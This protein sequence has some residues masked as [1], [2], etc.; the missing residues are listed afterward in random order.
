M[1]FNLFLEKVKLYKKQ[2]LSFFI[3]FFIAIIWVFGYNY[4]FNSTFKVLAWNFDFS[5]RK[6]PF[7]VWFIDFTLSKDLDKSTVIKD[8]FIISPKIDWE[9]SLVWTNIIRYKFLQK[10]TIWDDI[11]VTL[12]QSIKSIKWENLDQEYNYIISVIESPKVLKISP[13]WELDNLAQNIAVFFNIPMIPLT[14]LDEKDKLPC[15]IEIEPKLDWVCKWTT[16]SVMEF[17]PKDWFLWATKYKVTVSNKEWLLY[18]MWTWST[19]EISTPK[20]QYFVDERFSANDNIKIRFN[21]APDLVSLQSKLSLLE[22]NLKKDIYLSYD[23]TNESSVIVNIKWGRYKFDKSYVLKFDKWIMPKYGNEATKTEE[24]KTTFSYPF[25]N[26]V[27]V[28]QNIFSWSKLIDTMDFQNKAFIPSKNM[29]LKMFFEDRI[30]SLDTNLFS[31]EDDKWNKV[32][33]T[34]TYVREENIETKAISENKEAITLNL[35]Q[36]LKSNTKYK[37]IIKKS[38]NLNLENDIEREFQTSPDFLVT[39]Y[40]FLSYSKSCLYLN[41]RVWWDIWTRANDFLDS[42]PESKVTTVSEWEYIEYKDQIALWLA[43]ASNTYSPEVKIVTKNITDINYIEKWYCPPAKNWDNLY[44]IN[45]RLNPNSTYKINVKNTLDDE[46]WNLLFKPF[47]SEVKT[48]DIQEQDKYLYISLNKEI[49]LIPT[50]LPIVVNLQ[51]INLDNIDVEICELDKYNYIQYVNNRWEQWFVPKCANTYT[52]NLKVKNNHW[53]L[54]N[55]KFDVEKDIIGAISKANYILVKWN[56]GWRNQF[57]NVFIRS[58]LNV[59]FESAKNKNLLFVTDFEWNKIPNL[60]IEFINYNYQNKSISN[61]TPKYTLNKDT[62]VY[63]IEWGLWYNYIIVSNDKYTWIVDLNNNMFQDYDFK[64]VGWTA[65]SDMNY[66]YLYTERPIYKPGDTVFIKWLLRKFEYN[67]Y[68]KSGIKAGKLEILDQNYN[69]ISTLDIKLDSN[70]NFNSSFIIPKE[71]PLWE[72]SFRFKVWNVWMEEYYK[73]DAHFYIEEYKK[74]DFKIE[75]SWIKKDYSMWEKS[76]FEVMPKYYFGWNMVSTKWQYSVLTQNYFFDAKDYSNYQFGQGYEYFDCVYWGYCS[77]EDNLSDV[78][79]F[80]VNE[81]WKAIINYTFNSTEEKEKIYNFNVEVE[82]KDTKKTVNK[83]VSAIVHNTD[84]YVWILLPYY[85]EKKTWIKGE[86]ITLDYDANPVSWKDVKVEVIKR[87][88]KMVKKEWVDWVFYS[89]YAIEET[90]ESEFN[91]QTNKLGSASQVI[92]TKDSWEYMIKASY[93]W[94]NGKSFVSSSIVYV[95]WDDYVSWYSPNNDTTELVSEKVQVLSWDTAYYTLKTPINTWKALIII[96]KDDGILDYFVHDIKSYWD[97]IAI[98]VKSTYYPNYYLR[99]FVIWSEKWNDLP[100]YKRALTSTKVSTEYKKLNISLIKDKESYKPGD[101]VWIWVVVLDS[102]WNPIGWANGSIS[103]VDE[104]LLAL[105]WNPKKNPYAF[106]YDMKRYLWTLMYSSMINLI[107][108]LEVKDIT[109]WEKW[110]AWEQI[111]WWDSKKKRW[112]FKD[113]AFWQ[114][115][116]TTWKNW[117]VYIQ[118]EALPDNLTTWV[119]EVLVNT[120][121]DNKIWVAYETLTTTKKVIISDNLP[122]FFWVGDKITLSPVVFNKT[123]KDADFELSLD[124]TNVV[125]KWWNTRKLFIKSWE[126]KSINFNIEVNK[127][128]KFRFINV[129]SSKLDFKVKEICKKNCSLDNEDEIEKTVQIKDSTTRESVSTVWSTKDASFDEIIDI[130]HIKN[131]MGQVK[132]NYGATLF[133]NLVDSIDYLNNYPYGCAEQKTSSITPNIYIKKLYDSVWMSFDLK[134]KMIDYYD[135]EER[136]YKKKSLDQVIKE[137]IVDIRKF[138]KID[139]WFVY[140]YDVDSRYPN[141]SDYHL[142][143]YIL[144]SLSQLW[145]LGYKQEEKIMLDTVAY[146]KARFYKNQIEWCV[147]TSLNDCKYNELDRLSAIEAIQNYKTDDYETYKMYKLITLKSDDTTSILKKSIVVANLLKIKSL[148]EDEKTSLKAEVKKD[149]TKVINNELVYNPR[150]AYIGKSSEFTRVENTSLLLKA[151]SMLWVKEIDNSA[152]IIDNLNRWIIG[153][154]KNWTFWSTQDNISVIDAISNYMLSS[155]E[156]KDIN[157]ETKIKLNWNNVDEKVF[158]DKNKLEIVSKY[159]DIGSLKDKNTLNISKTWNWKV[160][161]DLSMDYYLPSK[162]VESRDEWFAVIKEYYDYNQYKKIDSLKKEEW[163]LY[164]KWKK[165]YDDLKYK[166]E[167]YEYLTKLTSFT[168]WQLVV[169]RNRVI[170]SETRDKVAFEWFIPAWAE[171]VNPNL[172][173]ST[174]AA[175]SFWNDIFERKEYRLDRFFGYTTTLQSWIYDV[176]YLVRFTHTGEYYV[177]PSY[178]NEFYNTEVFGRSSGEMIMVK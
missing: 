45:T 164:T 20:L 78:K 37:L 147:V 173:T 3:A 128:E 19:V 137:Y 146:L 155:E 49:N 9:V 135:S 103:I 145:G 178:I 80:R 163:L 170:T 66:L 154:K 72:F 156:L 47:G 123:W 142:T 158:N 67:W 162:N 136:A 97:R 122:S 165:S 168:V 12:K 15:P 143:S 40:K 41:N 119:V 131:D 30:G 4:Y 62:W 17:I 117:K 126:S 85:N 138:Q 151:I 27:L 90:K 130:S 43:T 53:N 11:S 157:F 115:D 84:S 92:K 58:D 73:N 38:I 35:K 34:L 89:D 65:T 175:F 148:S 51:T 94:K 116:F 21:F 91:L 167:T 86:F 172:A 98:K 161:Y 87:E 70:S 171:L 105:V 102:K 114:A 46:Y 18:K 52:K 56:A 31:F 24:S 132:V 141:Y 159:L 93:T 2:I 152:Y 108:K 79:E 44:V 25:L 110:W 133:N 118:S 140:W 1:Q 75:V 5:Y 28:Y 127:R 39:D 71:S 106:F 76:S 124:A 169:V 57:S 59:T 125:V 22:D 88:W 134:T 113:T 74:P 13:E 26:N 150:W 33:F 10:L 64:Y 104:S 121:E 8:N 69:V 61:N 153:Q 144:K 14:N 107:E 100:I 149:I 42:I 32:D 50:K 96:E 112:V 174:K 63:E 29:F 82:D 36:N 111:K 166:K 54:T 68:K 139:G 16:S 129:A 48:W 120:P 177:K 6:I 99:A 101:K 60:N 77:Y 176:A 109:N 83:T 55:N 95:A 81:E 160:Y 7:D 23:K